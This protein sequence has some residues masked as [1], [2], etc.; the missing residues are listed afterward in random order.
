[1]SSPNVLVAGE[2][3]IDLIP[4]DDPAARERELFRRRAGGAPANVAVAL[5]RLDS[6][7]FLWTSIGDDAFGE[8]LKSVLS[9][10]SIPPR[11]VQQKERASTG[12]GLVDDTVKGGFELYLDGTATVKFDIE[13]L[14]TDLFSDLEWIHLG[15]VLLA[16]EPSRTAMFDL[17]ER[18]NEF[19]C[20]I[21][22]DPNTRPSIWPSTDECVDTLEKVLT[23]VNIVI[24]HTDDFPNESFPSNSTALAE[25][26]LTRGVDV[27]A[28]TKGSDGAEVKGR[29]DS[30]WGGFHITHPGFDVEVEDPTGAGDTFTAAFISGLR[31]GD[32]TVAETL[33]LANASGAL[34][35]TQSGAIAAIPDYESVRA[36]I[37]QQN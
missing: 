14:P 17:I 15:G 30:P 21:S 3:V 13:D 4:F 29:V 22:F 36:W 20:T 9:S 5:S 28:I 11:F 27:V 7:P 2:S 32:I 24:G 6:P 35:T 34:A 37:Q 31:R 1:M 19:D 12:I 25:A 8:H 10:A 18:A 33:E 23:S 26:V 16:R